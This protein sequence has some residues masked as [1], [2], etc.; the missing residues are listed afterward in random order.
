MRSL[1]VALDDTPASAGAL[2]LALSLATKH[3]AAVSGATVLDVDYLT[4]REPGG[5]GTIYYKF[6]ADIARLKQGH[7]LTERLSERFLQQC[8]VRNVRGD[9]LAVEGHPW[10]ELRAAAVAHDLILIGRDS[11]LHG[12]PSGGLAKT[13]EKILREN[14][15]PL[16]IT[17]AKTQEPSRIA[18]AYDGSVPAARTL[19]IFTLLGLALNSEI[20]VM[21][22]DPAQ[23]I[24]DR[25]VGQAGA[26]LRLYDIACST[27]AI[28]SRANP[29]E[30][31]MAEAR[32]LGAELLMMG[33]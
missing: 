17:P 21:S 4:P 2:N 20:H 28:A 8:R 26:Y 19:Q 33:A 23:E 32:A 24:V 1:L 29:A 11:N 25:W 18:I 30:L 31:V 15:R 9:V 7:E 27:R 3:D 14:P 22:I 6:K 5:I 12:E 13:V 10:D 16:I